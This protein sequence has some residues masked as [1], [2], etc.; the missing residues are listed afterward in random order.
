MQPKYNLDSFKSKHIAI[1][2]SNG[3]MLFSSPINDLVTN[4]FCWF[5]KDDG[6]DRDC[7]MVMNNEQFFRM[8][9]SGE[10]ELLR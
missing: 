7:M 1:I 4:A 2:K 10:I 3:K 8:Q 6:K 5:S 9:A